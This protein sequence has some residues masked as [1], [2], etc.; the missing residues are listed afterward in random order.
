[1][2]NEFSG[3]ADAV[4]QAHRVGDVIV[5]LPAVPTPQRRTPH[6]VPA[7]DPH[8]TD[9][10][11]ELARLVDDGALSAAS[12]AVRIA[13]LSGMEGIGKTALARQLARATAGRFDGGELFVDFAA[14]R[15]GPDGLVPLAETVGACLHGLGVDRRFLPVSPPELVAMY[16]TWTASHRMLVVLDGAT[17]AAQVR[18]LVPTA[19][20][21]AVIV[22]SAHRMGELVEVDGA[23]LLMLEPLD[24]GDARS[25]LHD[26]CGAARIDAE[27]DAVDELVRLCDGLPLGLR[28]AAARLV[29]TPAMAI[30]DLVEEIVEGLDALSLD[31]NRGV[32]SVLTTAY[33]ALPLD[34]QRAYRLVGAAGEATFTVATIAA[35]LDVP[36]VR[37]RAALGALSTANLVVDLP[38]RRY[39]LLAL[40]RRHAADRVDDEPAQTVQDA[41]DRRLR[42]CLITAAFADLAVLNPERLRL[43]EFDA[44]TTGQPNP[45]GDNAAAAETWVGDEWHNLLIVLR[46]AMRRRRFELARRLAEVVAALSLNQ[47]RP[48]DLLEVCRMGVDAAAVS[49][50]RDVQARLRSLASRGHLDLHQPELAGT[51]LDAALHDAEAVGRTDL[52]ASVWE[53]RGRY[54]E[55]VDR[56][57]AADAYRRSAALNEAADQ[58]RGAALAVFFLAG[59]LADS[60]EEVEALARL[61]WALSEFGKLGD[62]RMAARVLTRLGALYAHRGDLDAAT[63]ALV[64]AVRVLAERGA[65]HYEAAAL[66]ALADVAQR[67]GDVGGARQALGR[68]LEILDVSGNARAD[69]IRDRLADL[70]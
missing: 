44:L 56:A 19:P 61:E 53:F 18:A 9:R 63:R 14:L 6:Q 50:R 31:G 70:G 15:G 10:R 2:R 66:E 28:V 27:P 34:A 54:L 36:I 20:G 22:T 51:A 32:A 13:V 24:A 35:L 1:M 33:R 40:V 5:Q 57:A 60:G 49:G 48:A 8:F 39:R 42:S 16:R 62:E 30:E 58:P 3:T 17:E 69:E 37:A 7:P 46:S 21:S 38:R 25:L 68:L 26:I 4:V 41:L 55:G 23:E 11:P 29:Q 52:L 47:R 59:L 64:E 43:Y 12:Q 45:F 65:T 67:G